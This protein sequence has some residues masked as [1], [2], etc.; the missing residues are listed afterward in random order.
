M[1]A[2][3]EDNAR[4]LPGRIRNH[5]IAA[6]SAGTLLSVL[7]PAVDSGP[8]NVNKEL[9]YYAADH[10]SFDASRGA[11]DAMLQSDGLRYIRNPA[12]RQA[13]AD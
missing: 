7:R 12:I 1:K 8:V 13:L 4:R 9:I 5:T 6:E 10:G 3:F 2:E 11:F